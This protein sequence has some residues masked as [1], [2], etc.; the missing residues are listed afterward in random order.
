M[1]MTRSGLRVSTAVMM[2]EGEPPTVIK[3]I[4]SMAKD[5]E[6]GTKNEESGYD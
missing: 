2:G 1:K 4:V 5:E 3:R 6:R